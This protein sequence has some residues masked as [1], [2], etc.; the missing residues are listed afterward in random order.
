MRKQSIMGRYFTILLF[1]VLVST[2]LQAQQLPIFNQYTELQTLINPAGVPVD[3][4]QYNQP[5]VA[6]ISFRRQWV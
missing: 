1:L 6:G 5:M 4:L 2:G 3:Y